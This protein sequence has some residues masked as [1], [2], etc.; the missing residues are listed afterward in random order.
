MI[1][2]KPTPNP[3][4]RNQHDPIVE[5][6]RILRHVIFIGLIMATIYTA[7]SPAGLFSG[8]FQDQFPYIAAQGENN[9]QIQN[10]TRNPAQRTVG[11]V[12]GHFGNDSG[13]VCPDGLREVDINQAIATL[14]QK[15]LSDAGIKT[16]ILKEFDERL[17]GYQA[18]VF[19]SIHNDSCDYINDLA[20]GFKVA[21]KYDNEST[22]LV[23][24]LNN[25]YQ[26]L[27]HLNQHARTITTHMTDYHAFREISEDTPGA[28]IEAGFM[29]LDRQILTENTDLVAQGIVDGIL[30]YLNYENVNPTS[31]TTPIISPTP[32]E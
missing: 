22:R 32:A 14:V 29:N 8:N 17:N 19:L 11:I 24:C 26:N 18:S 3:V 12:A 20:T 16:E 27:T 21:G 10:I 30:C 9:P 6:F 23:S 2:E 5:T 31:E 25:R 28:I 4:G 1:M 15:K 7:W 13:A